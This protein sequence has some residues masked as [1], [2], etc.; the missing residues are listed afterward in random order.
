VDWWGEMKEFKV[1]VA[2]RPGELARVT[3]ALANAAVNI[4]AIASESKHDASFLRVVTND[5]TTTQKALTTAGLKFDLS[6]LLEVEL[7]DRPG[8]L[9]K[10]AKRLSRASINVHSI[11]ILGSRNGRTDVA[12][13]VS[14]IAKAKV[15][16]K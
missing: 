16:L 10:V 2:D 15:A 13:V 8:E 14:D 6:D 1:F 5:V 7:L 11:Y 3:E 12:L 4:R 9:A